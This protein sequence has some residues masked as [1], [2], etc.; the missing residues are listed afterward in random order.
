MALT[1]PDAHRSALPEVLKKHER[2]LGQ[3]GD[4]PGKKLAIH[5]DV[6]ANLDRHDRERE[7]ECVRPHGGP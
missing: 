7:T 6:D 5:I 4:Y 3:L 1:S 2:A